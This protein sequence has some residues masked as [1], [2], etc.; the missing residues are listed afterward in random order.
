M[1]M[2]QV[3]LVMEIEDTFGVR[4]PEEEA[5]LMSTVGDVTEWLVAELRADAPHGKWTRA[6]VQQQLYR[7]ISSQLGVREEQLH[8][9]ARFVED[10]G[11]D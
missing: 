8:P 4:V 6:Q 9:G 3:E 5:Q 2:D 10:L 1:G 11:A 7:I